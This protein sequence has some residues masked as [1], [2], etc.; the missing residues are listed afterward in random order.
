MLKNKKIIAIFALTLLLQGCSFGSGTKTVSSNNAAAAT[1]TQSAS[2]TAQSSGNSSSNSTTGKTDSQNTGSA[3]KNST[4]TK[5]SSSVQNS[6][7]QGETLLKTLYNYSKTGKIPNCNF[8]SNGTT[9]QTVEKTWDKPDKTNVV[10]KDT[11]YTYNKYG[12]VFGVRKDSKIFNIELYGK[13]FNE[14]RYDD[15]EKTLGKPAQIISYKG[16]NT[17]VYNVNKDFQLTLDFYQPDSNNPNT[18]LQY[19]SVICPKVS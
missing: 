19:I 6:D 8:N 9:I 10:G 2:T 13:N 15:V 11:Y 17:L 18:T 14:I 4:N 5:A 16:E 12:V 3:A 1:K 7:T